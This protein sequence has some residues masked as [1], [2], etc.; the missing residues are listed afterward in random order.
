MR[1]LVYGEVARNLHEGD[2]QNS[3]STLID[4]VKQIQ[5]IYFQILEES[6]ERNMDEVV[7]KY[8]L[9]SINGW[10]E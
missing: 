10:T 9:S 2:C 1:K 8:Y 7:F 6:V 4:R 5:S 3:W